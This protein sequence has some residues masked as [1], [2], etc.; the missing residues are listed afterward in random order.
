MNRQF[1]EV[2]RYS[3]EVLGEWEAPPPANVAEKIH[4][5]MFWFNIWHSPVFKSMKIVLPLLVLFIC[6]TAIM[7]SLQNNGSSNKS[8]ADVNQPGTSILHNNLPIEPVVSVNE[9]M[10]SDNSVITNSRNNKTVTTK[11]NNTD[12]KQNQTV[13]FQNQSNNNLASNQSSVTTPSKKDVQEIKNQNKS[14]LDLSTVNNNET[15]PVVVSDWETK[16]IEV[17]NGTQQS[18]TDITQNT[19]QPLTFIPYRSN[20]LFK[21]SLEIENTKFPSGSFKLKPQFTLHLDLSPMFANFNNEKPENMKSSPTIQS[22]SITLNLDYHIKNFFVGTGLQYTNLEN[23]Q[24]SSSLLYNPQEIISQNLI[25]QNLNIEDKSYWYY[26][27]IQDSVIHVY[28]SVWMEVYDSTYQDVFENVS[29][30]AFD[31]LNNPSWKTSISI[32]E[33]PIYAGYRFNA[34]NTEFS[35]R[36]GMLFG[37]VSKTGGYTFMEESS[38]G[39]VKMNEVFSTKEMQYSWFVSAG[40]SKQI[41][42]NWAIELTPSYRSS[43]NG[44]KSKEGNST[45]KYSAWGIGLGMKYDF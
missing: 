21:N 45:F 25:G 11:N 42:E 13:N 36:G 9:T 39:L 22:G 35:L 44:L 23:K 24:S 2:D 27:Y 30:T 1:E 17:K 10:P 32:F 7:L 31:T 6:S 29:S 14:D 20:D 28:D 18:N 15:D 26:R 41:A 5:R 19:M 8:F 37:I 16:N 3:R 43:I 34:W 4:Q 38:M 12:N 40:I 33:I